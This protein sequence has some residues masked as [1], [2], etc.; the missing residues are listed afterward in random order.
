MAENVVIWVE[1]STFLFLTQKGLRK[2]LDKGLENASCQ[3]QWTAARTQGCL[4]LIS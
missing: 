4:G 1:K 2:A 3:T